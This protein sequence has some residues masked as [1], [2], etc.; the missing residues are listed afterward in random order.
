MASYYFFARQVSVFIDL[1]YTPNHPAAVA[2]DFWV[3]ALYTAEGREADFVLNPESYQSF[4]KGSHK[5][6]RFK[7]TKVDQ[8]NNVYF[9]KTHLTLYRDGNYSFPLYTVIKSENGEFKVDIEAT[10]LSIT[11]A[12]L[13][14][15]LSYYKSTSEGAVKGLNGATRN[16]AENAAFMAFGKSKIKSSMCEMAEDL[17]MLVTGTPD[18]LFEECVK[19]E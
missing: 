15:V 16:A 13:D 14:D 2:N 8:D 10:Q 9:V 5:K 17:T 19:L 18:S 1:I 7:L 3:S 4:I 12:I 6:D 11:D